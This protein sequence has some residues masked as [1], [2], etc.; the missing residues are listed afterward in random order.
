VR[1]HSTRLGDELQSFCWVPEFN[2]DG[3]EL[4]PAKVPGCRVDVGAD[5]DMHRHRFHEVA[6]SIYRL[7][8]VAYKE[9]SDVCRLW[10]GV[11]LSRSCFWCGR[12]NSLPGQVQQQVQ[13]L[14]VKL[15]LSP[16][17]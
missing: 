9:D 14:G 8:V 17:C 4:A 12:Q 16:S 3:F 7:D 6:K 13:Q 15:A 2:Y 11:S 5:L 1:R 10:Q